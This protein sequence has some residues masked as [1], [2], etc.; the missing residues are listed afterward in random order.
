[1]DCGARFCDSRWPL[2]ISHGE[3]RTNRDGMPHERTDLRLQQPLQDALHPSFEQN[4]LN[5]LHEA[6]EETTWF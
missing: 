1:I 4:E 6:D 2:E 5:R 3:G